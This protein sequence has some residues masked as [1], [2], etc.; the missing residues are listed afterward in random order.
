[1]KESYIRYFL[2]GQAGVFRLDILASAKPRHG[3][4]VCGN[5]AVSRAGIGLAGNI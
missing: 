4:I 5:F 2:V 3:A 1:V